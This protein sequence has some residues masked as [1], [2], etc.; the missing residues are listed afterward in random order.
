MTTENG[1]R[2]ELRLEKATSELAEYDAHLQTPS[3]SW[4]A[5]VRVGPSA[6]A[7]QVDFGTWQAEPPSAPP[8]WLTADA[9]A[10]LKAALRT[11]Q[12]EGRWPRRITRWRPEPGA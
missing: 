2:I 10:A 11:S 5:R 7:Q 8:E 6:G 4:R 12:A 9:R 1:G 3:M